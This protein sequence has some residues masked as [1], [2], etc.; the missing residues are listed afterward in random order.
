[1]QPC[2]NGPGVEPGTTTWTFM[3]ICSLQWLPYL[4]PV[5]VRDL[6]VYGI[7]GK[8][9]VHANDYLVKIDWNNFSIKSNF[10]Q[11]IW[12]ITKA[13]VLQIWILLEYFYYNTKFSS[14][15]ICFFNLEEYLIF[16]SSMFPE[17][18]RSKKN[19]PL[20][21]LAWNSTTLHLLLL[22]V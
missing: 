9:K 18:S 19:V 22:Y 7:L 15:Y 16:D 11:W 4:I 21:Q 1:M 17:L 2:S 5:L 8:F 12:I 10:C 14:I 3:L 13:S 6:G 20:Y